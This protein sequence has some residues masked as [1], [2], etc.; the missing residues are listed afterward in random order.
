MFA[1]R[2]V[3]ALR[4]L[5]TLGTPLREGT[6]LVISSDSAEDEDLEADAIALYD[7]EQRRWY[8]E[9]E[10]EIRYVPHL[11]WSTTFL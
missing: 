7:P 10:G 1:A 11:E 8:A 2:H 9:I 4:D 3:G 6:Q 5:S